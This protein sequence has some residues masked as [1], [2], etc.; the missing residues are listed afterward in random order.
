MPNEETKVRDRGQETTELTDRANAIP[1]VAEIL[2]LHGLHRHVLE[3][4]ATYQTGTVAMSALSA[5]RTY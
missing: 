1:G 5:T 3:V 2:R 4:A